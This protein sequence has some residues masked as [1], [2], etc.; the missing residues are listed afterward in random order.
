M[1]SI[2]HEIVSFVSAEQHVENG[3]LNE[4][5]QV[6]ANASDICYRIL[7]R[8]EESM[9]YVASIVFR[10][11]VVVVEV[12]ANWEKIPVDQHSQQHVK[13]ANDGTRIPGKALPR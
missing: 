5:I 7:E 6:G 3:D 10:H 1:P 13:Q 2:H 9:F 4:K 12:I 8:T 11:I